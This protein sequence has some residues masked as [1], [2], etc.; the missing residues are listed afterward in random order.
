MN[1][2]NDMPLWCDEDHVLFDTNGRRPD[3]RGPTVFFTD[4]NGLLPDGSP[5][6]NMITPH[7]LPANVWK[8]VRAIRLLGRPDGE[9]VY[10]QFRFA[11]SLAFDRRL[12]FGRWHRLGL[13][14]VEL[15][16]E[17]GVEQARPVELPLEPL[18]I[19]QLEAWQVVL[20]GG[21]MTG[22]RV[23]LLGPPGA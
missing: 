22:V 7:G 23:E 8:G 17:G 10:V 5:K 19:G 2:G 12:T 16:V 4:C 1:F 21:D 9:S 6:S 18:V 3:E 11:S 15:V 13:N 20:E 14:G